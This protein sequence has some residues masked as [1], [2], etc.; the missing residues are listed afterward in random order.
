MN[1]SVGV[2]AYCEK[3]TDCAFDGGA[4]FCTAQFAA[5]DNAWFCTRPC[6]TDSECGTGAY[7]AHDARG[8]AC[9]PL[10][11]GQPDASTDASTDGAADD[12]G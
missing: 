8:V 10:S 11:C 2:G 6:A 3:A 1:N 4:R 12:S 5:P 7:C 9:V